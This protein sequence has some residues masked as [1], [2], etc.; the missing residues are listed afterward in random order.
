MTTRST[1]D[2]RPSRGLPVRSTGKRIAVLVLLWSSL[3]VLVIAI[4]LACWET[5]GHV[6]IL[7]GPI[8][9]WTAGVGLLLTSET[10]LGLFCLFEAVTRSHRTARV[11]LPRIGIAWFLVAGTTGIVGYLGNIATYTTVASLESGDYVPYS[12]G[13]RTCHKHVVVARE[14]NP[15]WHSHAALYV[16]RGLLLVEDVETIYSGPFGSKPVAEGDYVGSCARDGVTVHFTHGS[17][18]PPIPAVTLAFAR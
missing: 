7:A 11:L 18:E 1:H 3:S 14:T 12:T 15:L 4:V 13:D 8:T 17:E 5:L 6:D 2:R 9:G 10:L 16:Q